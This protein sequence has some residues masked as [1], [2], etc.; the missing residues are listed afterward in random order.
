M[1]WLGTS[2]KG[3]YNVKAGNPLKARTVQNVLAWLEAQPGLE[4]GS[5]KDY[6]Y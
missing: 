3:W 1:N 5:R 2:M 6:S 4:N